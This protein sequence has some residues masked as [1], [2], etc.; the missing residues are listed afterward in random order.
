MVA[1]TLYTLVNDSRLIK[2]LKRCC[3]VGDTSD[4]EAFHSLLN[5]Y[6]RKMTRVGSRAMLSRTLLAVMDFNENVEREYGARM[7]SVHKLLIS[8]ANLAMQE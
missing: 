8:A 2:E 4:L 6:Y 1:G 5:Y 7:W 3:A